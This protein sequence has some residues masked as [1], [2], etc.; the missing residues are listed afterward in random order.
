VATYTK[1]FD[2]VEQLGKG[3]HQLHAAGHTFMVYLSNATP[4]QTLDA[5]KADMAGI[6]EQNGYAAA[7]IQNDWTETGGLGTM[8]AVDVVWTG[9]GAGFG[10]FQYVGIYNDT[11]VSPVDPL[12]ASYDR[13]AP[14]SVLVG[15]TFTVD[16]G[17]SLMTIQ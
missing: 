17:A 10:P 7:D 13:G 12:M 1:F 8:T 3:V 16:F 14:I 11:P 15:E 5:I 9:T 6:T 2:F 4:S